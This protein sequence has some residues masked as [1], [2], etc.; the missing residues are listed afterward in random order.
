[1]RKLLTLIL[2]MIGI[3]GCG[4][5]GSQAVPTTIPTQP[6]DAGAPTAE[7]SAQP[8]AAPPDQ[9]PT[10]YPAPKTTAAPTA[11]PAPEGQN[12]IDAPAELVQ[13]TQERLALL[14]QKPAAQLVI[15]QAERK[16]WPD[17]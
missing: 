11:Y 1:M 14:L 4:T 5:A 10:A 7:P 8:T 17:T 12:P 3:A 15:Q 6:P 2:V 13:A 16:Q 9:P